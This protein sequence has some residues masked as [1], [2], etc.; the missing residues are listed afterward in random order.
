VGKNMNYV[1]FY[2]N[3]IGIELNLVFIIIWLKRKKFKN[4]VG[5]FMVSIIPLTIVFLSSLL[6]LTSNHY[7]WNIRLILFLS[8]I[9]IGAGQFII[10]R[11]RKRKF[12]VESLLVIFFI[13]FFAYGIFV[14]NIFF[15]ELAILKNHYAVLL[16]THF[17][18]PFFYILGF[19][20]LNIYKLGGIKTKSSSIS[21]YKTI[22]YCY[23]LVATI[24][25]LFSYID[26][27]L[28]S[29]LNL[30]LIIGLIRFY[31]TSKTKK[32]A[33][34]TGFSQE[35]I[36]ATG[37]LMLLGIYLILIAL[38]V[39]LF[40]IFGIN[41]KT[42]LGFLG[43]FFMSFL[44]LALFFSPIIKIR[45]Q[46]YLG[47]NLLSKKF[48]FRQEVIKIM[49]EIGSIRNRDELLQK[50]RQIVLDRFMMEKLIIS[51]KEGNS[52]VSYKIEKEKI[53]K[54]SLNFDDDFLDWIWR[55]G[56][57]IENNKIPQ[58]IKIFDMDYIIPVVI[59]QQLTA[60]LFLDNGGRILTQ[61]EK[62]I[63]L[64]MGEQ[65]GLTFLN[66]K[67]RQEIAE[68]EKLSVF[69][70]TSSF[71]V[72]DLKN[73]VTSL[74]LLLR[75]AQR[76]IESFEFRQS[77]LKSLQYTVNQM[78]SLIHKLKMPVREK[79][80]EK[81]NINQIIDE[82]YRNLNTKFDGKINF[83]LD[84]KEPSWIYGEKD[85]IKQVIYNLITNAIEAVKRNG[86][87]KVKTHTENGNEDIILEIEDSG[88]GI[89]KENI[90]K[91]FEPFYSSKKAGLGIGLYQVKK[92]IEGYGGEI[93]AESRINEGTK[94][95][96]R[97]PYRRELC[98]IKRF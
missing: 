26:Y 43:A 44:F 58:E 9:Y 64:I 80:L 93:K 32:E 91:I 30:G 4:A 71:I 36:A 96:I 67:L 16:Y 12:S 85:E 55:K 28:L 47:R 49:E 39:K 86:E 6:F 59:T 57:I 76:H 27:Y 5:L 38:I 90:D 68:A 14:K 41:Y 52:F 8:A 81:I 60:I 11:L 34:D 40:M 95:K 29:I 98:Q 45:F 61:E 53:E 51:F 1:I 88:V 23:F 92:I 79:K 77:L 50:V 78:Q 66:L 17:R 74:S 21:F 94:F 15:R 13:L 33:E 37:N 70:R 87:I 3:L 22:N 54:E 75:N 84:L 48:D 89:A 25:L 42:F 10:N 46:K 19:V 31:F 7:V 72:H 69:S 20:I 35:T 65:I 83:L 24:S 2:L 73:M 62:D 18:N 97:F 56:N 82:I 63:F